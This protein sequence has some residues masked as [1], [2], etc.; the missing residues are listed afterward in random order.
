M[1]VV[2]VTFP[3]DLLGSYDTVITKMYSKYY[4]FF[5][6]ST[7]DEDSFPVDMVTHALEIRNQGK[8]GEI[9]SASTLS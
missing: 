4:S 1:Y 6:E 5:Y 3:N 9:E 2:E 7:F 8:K